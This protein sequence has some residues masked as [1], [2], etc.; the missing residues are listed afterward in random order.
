[1]KQVVRAI[2][3]QVEI[4]DNLLVFLLPQLIIGFWIAN[5]KDFLQNKKCQ[6]TS[7]N[8][9]AN[10]SSPIHITRVNHMLIGL[11]KKMKENITE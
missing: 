9:C 10:S 3:E 7:E 11:R 4:S 2:C 6:D 1:M 5:F 8:C